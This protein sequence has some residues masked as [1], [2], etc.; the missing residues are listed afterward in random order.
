[1]FIDTMEKFSEL[2]TRVNHPSFG[3]TIDIGHL[4]CNGELPISRYLSDWQ[5]ILWNVHIEDMKRKVHDHLMIG[6]GEVD[7][8]DVFAGLEA[9]LYKGGV[10]LELSRNSYDAVETARRAKSLLDGYFRV[11]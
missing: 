2:R 4:Q 9:S 6:E 5:E 7:F 1:M 11:T 8:A 10:F 3:L